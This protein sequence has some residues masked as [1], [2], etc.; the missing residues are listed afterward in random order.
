MRQDELVL[1]QSQGQRHF[2]KKSRWQVVS[3]PI[4]GF[5]RGTWLQSDEAKKMLLQ[6]DFYEDGTC[7][8]IYPDEVLVYV[9]GRK[10]FLDKA[11]N[12]PY[13]RL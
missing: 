6:G 8:C 10:L 13:D 9:K 7:L 5:M 1:E 3:C 12:V 4:Y 2:I 11:C